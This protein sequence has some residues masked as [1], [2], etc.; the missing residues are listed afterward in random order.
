MMLPLKTFSAGYIL[1]NKSK[2]KYPT[3]FLLCVALNIFNIFTSAYHLST[4]SDF[5]ANFLEYFM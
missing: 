2:A 5:N 3:I 1:Q 4:H